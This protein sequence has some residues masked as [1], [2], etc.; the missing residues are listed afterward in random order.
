MKLGEVRLCH[1][2]GKLLFTNTARE[3]TEEGNTVREV[4]YYA[5]MI[6]WV[7]WYVLPYTHGSSRRHPRVIYPHSLRVR[8]VGTGGEFGRRHCHLEKEG[9]GS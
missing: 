9:V 5:M 8:F 6:A 7:M 2:R 4:R 3:I 1:V